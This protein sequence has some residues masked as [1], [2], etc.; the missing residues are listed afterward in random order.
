[1][2]SL[3][4]LYKEHSGKTSDKW[5]SYLGVYDETFRSYRDKP[6]RLVEVG[7]QNGGSLEIWAKY[8]TNA[9][10]ITGVDINPK[11][12]ELTFVDPRIRVLVGDVNHPEVKD[13]LCASGEIDI[14]IDD[15][16][17]TSPD[18]VKTFLNYFPVVKHNG[19]FL[20]EDLHCSYWKKFDGGL[21]YPF[22]S[23][24][25]FKLLADVINLEHWGVAFSA[26]DILA[27]FCEKYK[28]GMDERFYKTIHSV[29]FL[30]S[31]CVVTRNNQNGN[32]LGDRIF[33]GYEALIPCRGEMLAPDEV[34]NPWSAE[35]VPPDQQII[36]LK[37]KIERQQ[38]RIREIES[39][40]SWRMTRP[41]RVLMNRLVSSG[42]SR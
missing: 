30:N 13:R 29:T 14:F 20:A 8:F 22:S 3:I 12:A 23:M 11:C 1:M 37:A 39:S 38:M 15:G 33:V 41:F 31:V 34:K 36:F 10:S 40:R 32:Q 35:R 17:H 28:T 19:V 24:T 5:S 21:F 9:V 26:N 42:K 6:V 25:F 7:V 27:G 2:K 18:I 16:S 4:D